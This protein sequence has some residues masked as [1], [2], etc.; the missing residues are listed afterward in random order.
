MDF[1]MKLPKTS[2]G[3]DTIWVI[4]DRLTKSAH[5][6][7]MKETDSMERLT[8]LYMKEVVSRHGVPTNGQSE[9]TIQTLEYKLRACV[10][11]FE[12]GWDKHLPSIEF[13]YNNSY[14]TSIKVAAFEALYGRKCRSPVC[15]AE[16]RDVQ[17]TGPEIV[18]KTTEKIVQIK[19]RIQAARDRQKSYADVRRK[20]LKF[21]VGDKVR[22]HS[23]FHMSNSK[24]CLS[25]K[26]LVI[27]LDEIHIDD[28]SHF[29]EEPVKIMDREVK[30]LKQSRIPIVKAR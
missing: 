27:P 8:R 25:D 18:H 11:D 3:Y 22:V 21:Q 7:P 12:N 13:L 19:S 29:V 15:W 20:P 28:E 14:H 9:R 5:F 26:S 17:L 4:V 16:V 23:T 6:L 30:Q 10:I 24:K 1:V 2:S